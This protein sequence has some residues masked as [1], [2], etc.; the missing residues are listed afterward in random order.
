MATYQE[1]PTASDQ[2]VLMRDPRLS[3]RPIDVTDPHDNSWEYC[4]IDNSY[5]YACQ[6]LPGVEEPNGQ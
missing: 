5:H 2:S 4:P 3:R 1:I 6:S